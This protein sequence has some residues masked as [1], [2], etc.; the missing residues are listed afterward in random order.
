MQTQLSQ[1]PFLVT[2][3]TIDNG[4]KTAAHPLDTTAK[5][6]TLSL[7]DSAGLT[8]QGV[9]MQHVFKGRNRSSL[10][11]WHS[12]E[13]EWFYILSG[14]GSAIIVEHPPSG[15]PQEREVTVSAGDFLG[16]PANADSRKYAH[17]FMS[18]DEEDLVYLC[19]GT[20]VD[21]VRLGTDRLREPFD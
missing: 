10:P 11:H 14:S 6:Q 5:R 7:G 3:E 15:E 9:H 12:A 20:R 21:L 18:G 2:K 19:G 16:F 1:N 8:Q 17:C 13:E 4:L